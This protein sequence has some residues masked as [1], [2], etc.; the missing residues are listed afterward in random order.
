M[1]TKRAR[2]LIASDLEALAQIAENVPECF[3]GV[4]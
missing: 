2:Q 1:L 4:K 3:K